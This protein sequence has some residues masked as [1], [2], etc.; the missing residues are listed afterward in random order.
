MNIEI[1]HARVD[2]VIVDSVFIISNKLARVWRWAVVH[3]IVT[4]VAGITPVIDLAASGN[5]AHTALR[6]SISLAL[7]LTSPSWTP[8]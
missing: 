6:L 1:A 2:F 4:F 3:S 5:S 8:T 7:F